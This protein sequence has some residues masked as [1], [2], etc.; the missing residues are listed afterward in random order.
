MALWKGHMRLNHTQRLGLV[1]GAAG[2]AL[3]APTGMAGAQPRYAQA[4]DPQQVQQGMQVIQQRGC[5][6][7]H[8]IPGIPGAQGTVG[9][10]LGPHDDVPPVANRN[11]IAT[12]PNGAVPNN[13]LN[14]L[15]TWIADPPTAKPGTAMP[16]L[17]V[18]PDDAAA[19]AAYLWSIQPDGT[20]T[21][22]GSGG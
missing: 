6:G 21:G 10:D 11:M 1:I 14:D 15:A 20:V 9:P 3:L 17:G 12:Y 16:K 8:T 18:S 13:S 2:L 4:I 19:A 22:A 5:G 7:C